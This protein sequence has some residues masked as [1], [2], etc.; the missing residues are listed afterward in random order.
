MPRA[1]R[2]PDGGPTLPAWTLPG[3]SAPKASSDPQEAYGAFAGG[4]RESRLRREAAVAGRIK[5]I[6]TVLRKALKN[7]RFSERERNAVAE[8]LAAV[9]EGRVG[10]AIA[11]L[12]EHAA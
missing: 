10:D 11:V 9:G 7:P 2:S 1:Q 12:E 6:E 5:A 8:A 4:G 3:R